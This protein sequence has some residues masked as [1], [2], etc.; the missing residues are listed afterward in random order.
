[1]MPHEEAVVRAALAVFTGH[2]DLTNSS[3][4]LHATLQDACNDYVVMEAH[5]LRAREDARAKDAAP[6]VP[7]TYTKRT[8]TENPRILTLKS[9]EDLHG[10]LAQQHYL[11]LTWSD[12][13]Q[14]RI[15]LDRSDP[16]W[17][18]M[19]DILGLAPRSDP[20]HACVFAEVTQQVFSCTTHVTIF[21][22]GSR[23]DSTKLSVHLMEVDVEAK[24]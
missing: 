1:M 23:H 5:I 18:L 12:D 2:A 15:S 4:T 8:Y 11:L 10:G 9:H 21:D 22:N 3:A 14:R 7:R 6:V 19:F 24:Q 17:V 20:V 13:T 16:H